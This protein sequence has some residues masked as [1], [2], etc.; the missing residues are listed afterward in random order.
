MVAGR[1]VTAVACAC[2]QGALALG[3]RI[4]VEIQP[5]GR[6]VA[7]RGSVVPLRRALHEGGEERSEPQAPDTLSGAGGCRRGLTLPAPR[8]DTPRTGAMRASQGLAG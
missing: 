4:N 5:D 3:P 1:K 7:A 2:R 6:T 8:A